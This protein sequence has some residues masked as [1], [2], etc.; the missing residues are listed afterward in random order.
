[1][2]FWK[3][4]IAS[5]GNYPGSI[6]SISRADQTQSATPPRTVSGVHRITTGGGKGRVPDNPFKRFTPMT[7]VPDEVATSPTPEEAAADASPASPGSDTIAGLADLPS[8]PPSRAVSGAGV[9]VGGPVAPLT[10]AVSPSSQDVRLVKFLAVLN[11]PSL[12]F[13]QLRQMSWSGVPPEVRPTVWRLLN[14]YLPANMDRRSTILERRR[15]EYKSSVE[16]LYSTRKSPIHAQML[17]QI[18][19]DILRSSPESLFEQEIT[20]QMFE[21]ILFI[22]HMRHPATGY[23]QGMNDLVVPFLVVFLSP[24][25]GDQIG[26]MVLGSLSPQVLFQ[27]EADCYWCFTILIDKIQDYFT[28]DRLGLQRQIKA[29]EELIE[30][31]DQPLHLHLQLHGVSYMQFVFRWMNCLMMRE[32]PLLPI[33]RL[34]DAYLAEPDG[35][36][37]L[38]LYTC[39]ALISTFSERIRA[40]GDLSE[41]MM[42]ILNLPTSDWT[43]K[44]VAM[45]LAEAY[46]LKFT[47]ENAHI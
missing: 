47:F 27:V 25:C 30:R 9:G 43:T 28:S 42:Y 4:S 29:L 13:D 40:T 31:I 36:S 33:I 26:K 12:D 21:R 44:E 11:A 18:Q 19:V 35:F 38:H 39:A 22:F 24:Y 41:I 1:M 23:V 2:S 34:W 3:T 5:G 37:T 15:V 32:L 8:P 10:S 17:H 20:K 14:G 6:Q 45:L 16:Q 46:R 7:L